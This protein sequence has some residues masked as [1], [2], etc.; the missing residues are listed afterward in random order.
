MTYV[1][2]KL[3]AQVS[4]K[5]L[6]VESQSLTYHA[7]TCHGD[8]WGNCQCKKNHPKIIYIELYD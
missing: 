1:L 2:P 6:M 4:H 5:D 3:I 7:K 8:L